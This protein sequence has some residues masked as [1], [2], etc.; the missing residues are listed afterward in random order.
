[1]N[2]PGRHGLVL[3]LA[4]ASACRSGGE[5]AADAAVDTP[6]V[7]VP[8]TPD[9]AATTL[10]LEFSATGCA[11]FQDGKV[12]RCEGTAPL[13]LTF[14]PIASA[15]LTRF[16]W[17]FGDRT[18]A[19][20]E[21]SPQH[22][23]AIPGEY[24]VTLTAGG[25]ELGSIQQ[26]HAGY[27]K[28][29]GGGPGAPCDVDVQCLEGLSCWCGSTMPCAPL[30][31]RG[32]CGRRC[33]AAAG[34]PSICPEGMVCADLSPGAGAAPMTPAPEDGWRQ[35]A[36]LRACSSDDDCAAGFRCR[37][38]LAAP[39]NKGWVRG[40]FADYPLPIG[41]R[42]GDASGKPVDTDCASR[43]CADLGAFR[44]CSAD[45][46][47]IGCPTGSTCAHFGDGRNLCL[48]ACTTADR[49]DDDPLL[50]CELA[51]GKGPLGFAVA[52]DPATQAATYCAPRRCLTGADCGPTGTCPAGG[53]NCARVP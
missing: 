23:Y 31:P 13:T 39:P 6:P 17:T 5:T 8:A 1:M 22:T 27:V 35:Q 32:L 18:P 7:D 12:P 47:A 28:V 11:S 30:L 34:G 50:A 24:D 25:A 26:R 41:A 9:T 37:E 53:G 4:A 38:L 43:T 20:S 2:R 52:N 21:R 14:T 19:S 51:G 48:A 40:C 46:G 3:L 45:C 15:G 10:A 16:L 29:A 44:R 49:C 33:D 36:C 42:C